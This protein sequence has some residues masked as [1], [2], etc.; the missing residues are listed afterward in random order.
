MSEIKAGDLYYKVHCQKRQ[1]IDDGYGNTVSGPFETQFTVRAAY[2]H[3]RG[4]EAVIASRL[5][6][7]HPVIITVRASSQTKQITADWQ[8]VDARDGAVW[9]V[10]DVTHETDRQ[11][12]SLL[13]ERGVAA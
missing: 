3:L 1:V 7:R 6:N 11:F 2:R 8:L 10:R 12:I 13:C 5:E 4:G 9:A